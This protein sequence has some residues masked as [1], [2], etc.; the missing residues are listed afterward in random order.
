M[1]GNEYTVS[2]LSAFDPASTNV[3][4]LANAILGTAVVKDAEGND[5]TAQFE[6]RKVEGRL[7]ILPKA[8]AIT[9]DSK[10]KE[11][12]Y[13]D[14]KFTATVTGL[15]EGDELKYELVREEGERPG[16]YAITAKLTPGENQNYKVT[17]T[18]GMLIIN[19]DY[20]N[21]LR[22]MLREAIGKGGEQTVT[23][24]KGTALPYD[25]M[26]TLEDH[27]QITLIFSYSYQGT[28]YQVTIPGKS[29]RAY[30]TIS[31]YGPL[32]LN[33]VYNNAS[34]KGSD[35]NL[36]SRVYKVVKGDCLSRIAKRLGLN[37]RWL[38]RFNN[39]KNPNRIYP[40]QELRY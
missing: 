14:P 23:W 39:L 28:D 30:T 7:E 9:V 21:E 3:C 6:V 22:T 16:T 13:G 18:D 20:L 12:G 26:K 2:G 24:N 4:N 38:A 5:V 35:S 17:V 29:A 40:G 19:E 11:L 27:P 15:V 33:D 31:W 25:V 10:R 37:W 8:A 1:E 32:Y 34:G 36:G